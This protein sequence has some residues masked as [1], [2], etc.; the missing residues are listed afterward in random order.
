MDAD[1]DSRPDVA[2]VADGSNR[3]SRAGSPPESA[4]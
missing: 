1:N 4:R 3:A 2:V